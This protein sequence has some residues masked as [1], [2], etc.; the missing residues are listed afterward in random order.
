MRKLFIP[1]NFKSIFNRTFNANWIR[2][3]II[4]SSPKKNTAIITLFNYP[5]FSHFVVMPYNTLLS[6]IRTRILNFNFISMSYF[7]NSIMPIVLS[8]GRL[9]IVY[10]TVI[11]SISYQKIFKPVIGFISVDMVNNIR[12]SKFSI[13]SFFNNISIIIF[14]NNNI[15]YKNRCCQYKNNL[16]ALKGGEAIWTLKGDIL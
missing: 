7:H 10:Y 4:F 8:F 12:R 14:H 11:S 3:F 2:R 9:I 13:E 6:W 16:F 1:S 5:C 15:T